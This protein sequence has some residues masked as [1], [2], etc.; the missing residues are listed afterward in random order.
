MKNQM[1]LIAAALLI[2]AG[3]KS[4]ID[5]KPAA[6]VTEPV[7]QTA[8][9]TAAQTAAQAP[10]EELKELAL[11]ADGSSIGFV[12]AKVTGDHTGGFKTFTGKGFLSADGKLA[13]TEFEVDTTAIFTDTEKLT[14][15]LRSPDF[16][17]VEKFPKASFVSTK[18]VE[19]PGEGKTHDITGDMTIREITKT[20]TFPAIVKAEGDTAMAISEFTLKR[21]DFGIVYAGKPDDLIKEEVLMKISLK[22]SKAQ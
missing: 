20:I 5:N 4:E 17:D 10:A 21:S 7:T 3:C 12:G 19:A 16:F 8:T 22:M 1:L 15:H 9:Q 6:T 13:K 11:V 14:T 2:S 18:I